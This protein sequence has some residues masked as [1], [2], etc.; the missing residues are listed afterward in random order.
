MSHLEEEEEEEEE[1]DNNGDAEEATENGDSELTESFYD[2]PDRRRTA[3]KHLINSAGDQE[4]S[5]T[6][7]IRRRHVEQN[8][9]TNAYED[10]TAIDWTEEYNKERSR[11]HKLKRTKGLRGYLT[12]LFDNA[13]IW[14]ILLLTGVSVGLLSA[15]IDVVSVWLGDVKQGVCTNNFYLSKSF[16][17]W[18]LSDSTRCVDFSTWASLLGA[19]SA[20]TEYVVQ[21]LSFILYAVV[22]A[23]SAYLLVGNYAPFAQHS[24]IPEIK[25]I[26]GGYIMSEFLGSWTL[27]IKALGLCLAVASGLWLGKEGPLVHVACCC[28]QAFIDLFPAYRNNEAKKREVLSAASAAGISVAFGAPI[29]GVLFSLEQVS[30]FFPDKV[31][32]HSFVCAMIAAVTL[33]AMNPFRTGKLVL[34]QAISDRQWRSFE[35]VYFAILG[36]IGGLCGALFIKLNVRIATW[37]MKQQTDRYPAVEVLVTT[38]VTAL[39]SYPNIFMRVQTS[40][41]VEYLFQDC[42]G[43]GSTMLGL[44]SS[45]TGLAD[46][47]LLLSAAILGLLLA[48]ATFGLRIPA[49]II[50]PSMAIGACYGRGIGLISQF[51]QTKYPTTWPFSACP[52]EGPCISPGFYAIV[53]AASALGGVTRLT[54]S[55]VVIM[56]ELTGALRFV[57]PIMVS[58]MISKWVGDSLGTV[59]IYESWVRLRDY[60]YI[61]PKITGPPNK[62]VIEVMTKVEELVII[63]ANGMSMGEL[64]SIA[65][66][67]I[68]QGFP[69]VNDLQKVRFIGFITRSDLRRGLR[70]ATLARQLPTTTP[71]SFATPDIPDYHTHVD[72]RGY[73]DRKLLTINHH[74]PMYLVIRLFQKL[75]RLSVYFKSIY[76]LGAPLHYSNIQRCPT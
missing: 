43:S 35:V 47:A 46:V 67:E 72:L 48:S 1:E 40:E 22:F 71:C 14:I 44:C 30:Y 68:Y 6:G 31:M 18:G 37:R 74:S 29:G 53:G 7:A 9:T 2:S 45:Q 12:L 73:L 28:A 5:S 38:I 32:W 58:V 17:C 64:V 41:L 50:L 10:F 52:L 59:G 66:N 55:L 75:V 60:P 19:R 8:T 63:P 70:L 61:D 15:A 21:Y 3:A 4:E 33:Q 27:V 57:L 20:G 16:C 69:V 62:E 65:E 26:L 25:A 24:G 23:L 54:V 51:L 11:K 42:P 36:V 34:Y 76:K 49:G 39:I 13:N 56:F